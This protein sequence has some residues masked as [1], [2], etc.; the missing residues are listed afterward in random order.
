LLLTSALGLA[1]VSL[2]VRTASEFEEAIRMTRKQM[3][4]VL[5]TLIVVLAVH[6]AWAD[7]PQAGPCPACCKEGKACSEKCC[8][9]QNAIPPSG[10]NC[11]AFLRCDKLK[12]FDCQAACPA[13]CPR[14]PQCT[15]GPATVLYFSKAYTAPVDCPEPTADEFV[16]ISPRVL[17]WPFPVDCPKPIECRHAAVGMPAV[18]LIPVGTTPVPVPY[19][20]FAV[21]VRAPAPC[22]GPCPAAASAFPARSVPDKPSVKQYQVMAKLVDAS[23]PKAASG[24]TIQLVTVEGQSAKI[25]LDDQTAKSGEPKKWF[26]F[27]VK[28]FSF[29][30]KPVGFIELNP[31][32]PPKYIGRMP[33]GTLAVEPPP[34]MPDVKP[35]LVHTSRGVFQVVR[36]LNGISLEPPPPPTCAATPAA[37]RAPALAPPPPPPEEAMRPDGVR[38]VVSQP[39]AVPLPAP[40]V[41]MAATPPFRGYY[42]VSPVSVEP[43]GLGGVIRAVCEEGKSRLE[44]RNAKYVGYH[45]EADDN[46][47][48]ATM[49]SMTY[50][51]TG[52]DT[53]KIFADHQQVAICCPNLKALA[54]CVTKDPHGQLVLQG[55]VQLTY[56]KKDQP[57]HKV[58]VDQAF[59]RP[60]DGQLRF[61]VNLK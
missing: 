18:A 43:M 28:D 49:E 20:R 4:R 27:T 2:R 16:L 52:W 55:H 37:P 17:S 53:L 36:H 26:E 41:P 45:W 35:A 8:P 50:K 54:D 6:P 21:A 47:P 19:V 57:A 33:D 44:F 61:E 9:T 3:W 5:G 59:L 46:G 14:C 51:M 38:T 25:P 39:M 13:A 48:V 29:E 15:S 12:I 40:P 42:Q 1:M 34:P 10:P 7:D 24:F 32:P 58:V 60:S 31:N 22:I 23:K 56:H 11:Q 30:G